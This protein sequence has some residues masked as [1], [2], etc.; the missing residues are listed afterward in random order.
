MSNHFLNP[1]NR[2]AIQ[3][4]YATWLAEFNWQWFVTL[5]FRYPPHPEQAKKYFLKWIHWIN[6]KLYNNRYYKTSTGIFW[7]L[8]LE[9]HKSGVIHFHALLGDIEDLN[10]KL[11]R[12]D[13]RNKWYQIAGLGRVDPIDDKLG[14]VTNYV[15]KY[16]VKGGEI[17]LSPS[18]RKFEEQKDLGV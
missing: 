18:L 5:T 1:L 16:I 12:K 6:R 14:A 13:A 15:S 7:V 3:K 11:S 8:A 17:E 4:E 2:K 10:L 9:Y